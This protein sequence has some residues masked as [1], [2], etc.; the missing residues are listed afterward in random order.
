MI[1]RLQQLSADKLNEINN[2]L[3][4]I[5]SQLKSKDKTLK[6]AGTWKDLDDDFFIE[7]TEKLHNNRA[8]DRQI[9]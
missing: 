5:E 4:K 2:L 1:R 7:M 8:N 3:G 6:L 9:N